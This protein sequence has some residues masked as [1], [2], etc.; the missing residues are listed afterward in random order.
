MSALL[1]AH[2]P[3]PDCKSS[4]AL[5]VYEDHTFCFSCQSHRWTDDNRKTERK[6]MGDLIMDGEIRALP[7]RKISEATAKKFGYRLTKLNGKPCHVAPYFDRQG[8]L[9]AQK[10]R[11]PNKQFATRG[12]FNK[13]A[14]FGEKLFQ[15]GGKRIVVVEGELD[16]MAYVEAT[17]SW[18]CVSVPN[19]AQAAKKAIANALEFLETFDEVCF[20]F[21]NDEHGEAAARNCAELISPGK[22]TI[23]SLPLK[24]ASDMLVAGRIKEL[25]SSVW[26]AKSVRPDGLVNGKDLWDAV[27][28]PTVLGTPYPWP[29]F[30]KILF[31]IQE[32]SLVC[33][34]AGSGCG[35]SSLTSAIAY[36]LAVTHCQNVGYVALEESV[37]RTGLRFMSQFLERQLHLPQELSEADR[38]KAFDATLGTGRFHL[39]DHFGSCDSDHLLNKLKFLVHANDVK[40]IVI[41]HLSIMLSGGDFMVDGGDERKQVDYTM[42]KLRQFCEQSGASIIL[43]SH[44]RRPQG[45]QGFEDGKTPTLSSLRSSQSIAQL[46]DSVIALSRNASAGDNVMSVSCLKNR[47]AGLTGH[48]CDL[49]YDSTTGVFTEVDGFNQEGLDI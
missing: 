23:A 12:D 4:D 48:I 22:A 10:L 6:P 16:A 8:N 39:Y 31:G 3:C 17:K 37:G 41:D 11:L 47:Y 15:D 27:S 44:L 38:K 42:S 19:G 36:D 30:N 24:D 14:L 7:A 43:V 13:V 20:M 32:R 40:V 26:N 45:D 29:S 34:T 18:P 1:E 5:T 49:N 33:V 46:S 35:K 9:V 2:L 28:R 21:D 25:T